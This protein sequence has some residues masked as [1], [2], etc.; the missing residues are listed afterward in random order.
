MSS[1]KRI[2]QYI[3]LK[4][5][6]DQTVYDTVS[7]SVK[8]IK[9]LHAR[10]S[11]VPVVCEDM[12]IF[13]NY[14]TGE[15]QSLHSYIVEQVII[16]YHKRGIVLDFTN[17]ELNEIFNNIYYGLGLLR[18]KIGHEIYE[19]IYNTVM[20]DDD[21]LI[22]GITIKSEVIKFLQ[23]SR[24][25]LI[26]T[27]TCFPI[28]EKFLDGYTSYYNHI[29]IRNEASLP[30]NCV[31][32]LFGRAKIEDSNW[33]YDDKILLNF[34]KSSFSSEYGLKNLNAVI[35]N[36]IS[37]KT[38]LILGNTAKDWLF[39]F[40][41]TPIYGGNIYDNVKGVYMSTLSQDEDSGLNQFLKDIRFEK[42]TKMLSVLN[43][44]TSSLGT[45]S[46]K[47]NGIIHDKKYDFFISHASEDSEKVK[48]LVNHLRNQG[49]S[50]WVDY[51][52]LKD[53]K[54]WQRIIEAL[55]DAR[56]FMPFITEKFI[57]KNKK[58]ADLRS[59]IIEKGIDINLDSSLCIKLESDLEGVQ[60]ELLMA[61][62]LQSIKRMEPYSIPIILSGSSI[63]FNQITPAY[64]R[65]CS[66]D[67]K[68]LPQSLFWGLQMYEFSPKEC[69]SFKLD[70]NRYKSKKSSN[71]TD[72]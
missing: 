46:K 39:R 65:N 55:Y 53:G 37:R 16:H 25:P 42:E 41:I 6:D 30:L 35:T 69:Q 32:H 45:Q 61:D 47:G 59:I 7:D 68:L 23:I 58:Q 18:S 12:F 14:Q 67:S 52:N 22:E 54:Y 21:E 62:K 34:F 13:T 17:K 64:I 44:V 9:R 51:E 4:E 1:L 24:F 70:Y 27:T 38:L 19:D 56:Y 3:N 57:L 66:E 20:D 48:I 33:G 71:V 26:I 43:L 11:L 15:T 31:Y 60:I 40:I 5:Y 36:G 8:K 72:Q 28:L 2:R 49:L 50:V 63:F 29:E 10:N